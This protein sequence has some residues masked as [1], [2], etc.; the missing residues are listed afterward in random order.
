[1]SDSVA[2]RFLNCRS[3]GGKAI[4]IAFS[5]LLVF[6]LSACGSYG[7]RGKLDQSVNRYND[8]V[9]EQKLDA[10]GLFVSG[11]LA[12]EFSAR[13]EA[14]RKVKIVDYRIMAMKYDEKKSEAEVKVE[15][16]Y[17]SLSTYLMKTLVDIQQWAY[18]EEGGTKKWRLTSLLPEF[19]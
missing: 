3:T 9:R 5:A 14:A 15:V 11:P 16:D 10:A 7:I 4:R 19:K 8:L 6:S 12:K 2:H 1:M 18:R 13:A 17:Y